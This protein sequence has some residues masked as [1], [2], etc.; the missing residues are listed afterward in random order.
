MT[1]GRRVECIELGRELNAWR[2]MIL[3]HVTSIHLHL[4]LCSAS[5]LRVLT[6][7]LLI[8]SSLDPP[9]MRYAVFITGPAGAGKSTFC[10]ALIT[11]AQTLG[12]TVH[13]MNLDP[14]A[15]KFDYE[16]TIDIRELISLN[17]VMDEL[18][19]GPNGGLVYCFE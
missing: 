6:H 13:L 2:L 12:R 17:D 11:H 19:F 10:S 7:P 3:S 9:S 16:P 8:Y 14:A 15:D 1:V 4:D 5:Y 18:E